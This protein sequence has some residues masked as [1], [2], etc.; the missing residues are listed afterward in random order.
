[1]ANAA[2]FIGFGT[3]VRGRE[4]KAVQE[5]QATLQYYG[6][7]QQQGVIESFEPAFLEPHGGDLGGFILLRGDRERLARLR[8]DEEFNRYTLRAS[9]VV[10]SLGVVSATIGDELQRQMGVYQQALGELA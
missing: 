3:P 6:R 5:F 9:L 4:R 10:E 2:L 1:M 8:T 7:L